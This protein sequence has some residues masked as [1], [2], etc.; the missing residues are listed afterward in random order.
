MAEHGTNKLRSAVQSVK[1]TQEYMYTFANKSR[2][3]VFVTDSELI[4]TALLLFTFSGIVKLVQ[5]CGVVSHSLVDLFEE[6]L[7]IISTKTIDKNYRRRLSIWTRTRRVC[8]TC[9]M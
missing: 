9:K 2:T 4:H 3:S 1:I 6:R 5:I 8:G 7:T